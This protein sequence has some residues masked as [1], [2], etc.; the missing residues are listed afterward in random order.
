MYRLSELQRQKKF[1]FKWKKIRKPK[2]SKAEESSSNK[3]QRRLYQSSVPLLWQ[4]SHCYPTQQMYHS[5]AIDNVVGLVVLVVL[6]DALVLAKEIVQMAVQEVVQGVQEDVVEL[7]Q[8]IVQIA[9]VEV[10]VVHVLVVAQIIVAVAVVLFVAVALA[11]VVI[12]VKTDV[13]GQQHDTICKNFLAAKHSKEHH[14][15]C[16]EGLSACLQILLSCG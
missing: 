13:N 2:N 9:A 1:F 12:L 10:V 15:H 11:D 6:L 5:L 4:M 14:F 8:V 16:Y 7:V 3:R